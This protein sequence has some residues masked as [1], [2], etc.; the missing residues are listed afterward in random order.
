MLILHWLIIIKIKQNGKFE[1]DAIF[2]QKKKTSSHREFTAIGMKNNIF[3]V[4]HNGTQI[5]VVRSSFSV[6]L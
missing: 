4:E 6:S 1:T 2:M 3:L 5:I